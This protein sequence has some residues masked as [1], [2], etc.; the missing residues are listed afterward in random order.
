MKKRLRHFLWYSFPAI[1]WMM[2]IFAQSSIP[3]LSVP[4]MGFSAQDKIAHGIEYA[5][6]GWL[7]TRAF[8]SQR[9]ACIK[10]NAI[11]LA[12]VVAC[13]YGITDEIHQ[14]LVPGRFADIGDIIADC[15]GAAFVAAIYFFKKKT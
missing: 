13:V 1:A 10:K 7:L 14:G 8:H 3:Y 5:I 2:A 11:W 6:L 12:L 15:I 4:D 9:R